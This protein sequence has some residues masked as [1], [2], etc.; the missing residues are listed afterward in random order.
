MNKLIE[1]SP[2][3]TPPTSQMN[4]NPQEKPLAFLGDGT[5]ESTH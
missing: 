2:P 3:E 5:S 1:N 4:V